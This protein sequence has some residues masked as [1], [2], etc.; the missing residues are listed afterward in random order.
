MKARRRGAVVFAPPHVAVG[1]V[2]GFDGDPGAPG[3]PG[4]PGEP[5]EPGV[6]GDP[7]VPGAGRL[8]VGTVGEI[9][10]RPPSA[11]G[12]P[13]IGFGTPGPAST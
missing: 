11:M 9:G 1:L 7:G 8:G 6:P 10:V 12:V 5:G 2:P 3:V 13:G 4:V